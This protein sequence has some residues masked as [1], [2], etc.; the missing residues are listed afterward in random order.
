[1]VPQRP[2]RAGE[3]I[4]GREEDERA[5]LGEVEIPLD[6]AASGVKVRG[7]GRLRQVG[8]QVEAHLRFIIE[9][10][11]DPKRVALRQAQP[12]AKIGELVVRR[13]RKGGARQDRAGHLLPHEVVE[14][15]PDL[16]RRRMERDARPPARRAMRGG[17]GGLVV[18]LVGSRDRGAGD[19]DPVHRPRAGRIGSV[20]LR[21]EGSD[22]RGDPAGTVR[23]GGQFIRRLLPA[24]RL[25]EPL[26]RRRQVLQRRRQRVG[27]HMG[28]R[29]PAAR[30]AFGLGP[31]AQRGKEIVRGAGGVVAGAP[32]RLGALR[33]RRQKT[34]SVP[35]TCTRPE[36]P[37]EERHLAGRGRDA[38]R[39]ARHLLQ[40]VGLVE[41]GGLEGGEEGTGARRPDR[42]VR[43]EQCVVDDQQVGAMGA[44][45]GALEEA[46]R[47]EGTVASA[48]G[49]GLARDAVPE[50][51]GD[52]RNE[53]REAPVGGREGPALQAREVPALGL[54]RKERGSASAGAFESAEA[55]I[56]GAPLDEDG[57]GFGAEGP[58][59]QR[60][61]LLDE[62][63]L[64]ADGVGGDDDPPLFAV[65]QEH[66]GN[67]IGEGLAD[68]GPGLDHQVA[69]GAEGALD[70]LGHGDLLGAVLVAREVA[71]DQ[72]LRAEDGRDVVGHGASLTG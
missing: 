3:H 48:A 33:D 22:R 37:Q 52:G 24:E 29:D 11:A 68:A 67:Q 59:Q 39:V 72:T 21:D 55:E 58:R 27:E 44:A 63:F 16:E 60:D 7:V 2:R 53:V 19:F 49:A 26:Q 9:R 62:L 17:G 61:V 5:A 54:G 46:P 13:D 42:Q 65:S 25:R 43:K 10:R 14:H 8:L 34:S 69:R 15:R 31:G 70:G 4:V 41:D 47:V 50:A 71:G 36:R 66:R 12:A 32:G 57:L 23:I 56:V 51:R 40:V 64:E 45:A 6:G 38:K 20:G 30:C 1:M 18:V 35:R 28:A